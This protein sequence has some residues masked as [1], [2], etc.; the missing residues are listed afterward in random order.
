[1]AIVSANVNALFFALPRNSFRT[2]AV[3]NTEVHVFGR[4]TQALLAGRYKPAFRGLNT[5]EIECLDRLLTVDVVVIGVTL[6]QKIPPDVFNHIFILR[7]PRQHSQLSASQV[8]LD[9][10]VALGHTKNRPYRMFVVFLANYS[11]V[12]VF[13]TATKILQGRAGARCATCFLRLE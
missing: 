8:S 9:S 2:A 11:F 5:L 7:Q 3:W 12:I 6:W 4:N 10:N 13:S 1:M